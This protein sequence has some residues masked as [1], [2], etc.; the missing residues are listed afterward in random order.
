VLP[1][2]DAETLPL[3]Y[4]LNSE[5]W[6]NL[7]AYANPVNEMQFKTIGSGAAPCALPRPDGGTPLRD[8]IRQRQSCRGFLRRPMPLATLGNLLQHTYGVNGVI[9][10]PEGELGYSR[11]VPS[12]GALYPLE[13]YVA[14]QSVDGLADG[15]YHYQSLDHVLE[16][17]KA[18]PVMSALGDLLLGQYF[19]DSANAALVF[20][21]V[22][23]RTLKKYGPRG[24]RYVLFEAGHAAQN[25]SLLA[26]EGGLASICVGGFRD[27]RLN[28]FLG[29]DGRAEAALYVVGVGYGNM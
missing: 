19:L 23:Q 15:L 11:A 6:L 1:I 3:L 27:A 28:R 29:L 13:I 22:F 14:I 8:L 17:L 24:Y 18:E 7:D 10:G 2:D 21:G 12:A 4:H 26:G 5:P 9:N 20:T 25:A 16:P